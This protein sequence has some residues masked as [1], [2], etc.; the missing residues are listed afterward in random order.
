VT[1]RAL[2]SFT[3]RAR[4]PEAL[5]PLGEIAMNLRWSWD[6]R[7]RDLFRWVDLSA[8]RASGGDPLKVLGRVGR[9]RF[10]ELAEDRGF[11]DFM[12]EVYVDFQHYLRSGGWFQRRPSPLRSVAYFSP[13]FGLTEALPQY[14]GGLGVLAGDHLKA[15][16]GLGI[17]IIGIG[18]FYREGYF[19]QE[20]NA[21]GQQLEH[22]L[23]LDPYAMPMTPTDVQ[24][25]VD[26]A[27]IPLLAQVWRVDVGRVRLYLLDSDV[28]G[29]HPAIRTVTDRLYGGDEEHRLIQEILLGMGGVKALAALGEDPQV[30]HMNE[31]HAGFLSLER[32][33][34]LITGEGLS[35]PEAIE[36]NRASTGFTTHTPVSAGIDRF[37]RALM[38]RYFKK[39]A[40][41]CNIPFDELMAIGQEPGADPSSPF[42]MAYMSLRLS[43]RANSVSKLH[44]EVSR[45]IFH[46]LWPDVPVEEVPIGSVT[47]GV[48]A[49]TWVASGMAK[50]YDRYVMPEWD[51]AGIERWSAIDSARDD[52]IWR[53]REA[54][55]EKLVMNARRILKSSLI[56]SGAGGMDVEWA[57]KVLD[58]RVLTIGFARRF[59][60]YKRA[61]LLFQYPERLRALLMNN[62][63][64]VQVVVAGKSH[65]KDEIGKGMIRQIVQFSHDPQVRQRVVFLPDYSMATARMLIQGSDVWLNNPRRPMEA[66]GTSGEKAALNGVLN[67]S[68]RDG[69]WDEM[70]NGE[71]GWAIASAEN[72][73]DQAKRDAVEAASLFDI[74]ERLVVPRFYER[75]DTSVP[76]EWV[77]MLKSSLKSL[78]PQVSASRMLRDYLTLMYEPL[79]ASAD[80]L[81]GDDFKLAKA[82]AE[83][84]GRVTRVW[85]QVAIRSVE[86]GDPSFANRGDIRQV[87]AI[88]D[89]GELNPEDVAVQL[90]HGQVGPGDEL[91]DTQT[92]TME[93]VGPEPQPGRYNFQ[94][95]F[96]C[97]VA[98]RYGFS[99]RVVPN[100]PNLG[101][102]AEL[103]KITWAA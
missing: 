50:L 6:P 83:W 95:S 82:L 27:G 62:E 34:G 33:R 85:S 11:M 96:P 38:E 81:H 24:V 72:Y 18:L 14:S 101:S 77:K 97:E 54:A 75:R 13:E 86:N 36:A 49:R 99:L 55:R 41:E 87:T 98:G 78:A 100:H 23:P 58:P 42:N 4:L 69:W 73:P 5:A 90:I 28:E 80:T 21:D 10:E 63:T 20:L 7:T 40:Q 3:V 102:F 56:A 46:K 17:P 66:C 37:P 67:V 68:I 9:R 51:K 65:P 76:N 79:A 15:A 74:L 64:P 44:G 52:E 2:R 47:N 61:T 103:G 94:G 29:S 32:I 16:S 48:H 71:N 93:L 60:E 59:A 26:L 8:W 43:A 30:F 89:L 92:V 12:S 45:G 70:F 25:E 1:P 31:G 84:K 57:D 91:Y 19:R 35:F 39:W 22:Y 53:V 88:L